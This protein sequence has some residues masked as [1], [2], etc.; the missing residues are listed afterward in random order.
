MNTKPII[1]AGL[2]VLSSFILVF[3]QEIQLVNSEENAMIVLQPADRITISYIDVGPQG[4]P[5]ERSNVFTIRPDGTIFHELLGSVSIANM[6]IMEAEELL[7]QKF[8]QFFTQP[9]VALS[10]LEKT[11][12]KV[13]LYGE[14]SRIGVFPVKPN[15]TIAEFIIEKGGTTPDADITRIA[16]SRNDGSKIIFDMERYLYSNEPINNVVLKDKDKIIVPRKVQGKYGKLSKN[17]IL[18]YGN[19]LEISINEMA[20]M[21]TNPTRSESYIVDS[22]GNIFHRLFGSVHLGGITVDKAQ[23]VLTEMAKQYYREPVVSVDVIELSSRNVFVFGEVVRPGIYP[24]EGNIR[25]AEFL[26]NI[27]GMTDAADLREIVVTRKQGKPV[28]FDMNDFLFK[29]NDRR[30]IFLEDGDRIIVQKRQRGIFVK[31]S[32]KLQPLS[33]LTSLLS[34]ILMIYLYTTA[35]K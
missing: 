24:I 2:I 34:S 5:I 1:T 33:T 14:V 10:V 11:S 8:S 3:A 20:L 35:T 29:R 32:E 12:I 27:G 21:E 9:K 30:N 28:V 23:G 19:V 15:T 31:L 22:E 18:Q 7:T 17:Y 6:T 13:I 4:N 16:I 26:A 25:L